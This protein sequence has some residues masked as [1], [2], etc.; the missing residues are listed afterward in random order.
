MT[1]STVLAVAAA[2]ALMLGGTSLSHAQVGSK[3]LGMEP[4]DSSEVTQV[5]YRGRART[6][7]RRWHSDGGWHSGGPGLLG[8]PFAAAAGAGMAAGSIIGGTTGAL[9][10]GP[11]AAYGYNGYGRSV[12]PYVS[13][14][15]HTSSG[16]PYYDRSGRPVQPYGHRF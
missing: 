10:G 7:N 15:V 13:G 5:R 3:A 6:M 14:G 9:F 11:Y 16:Y 2:G 4:A 12:E 8:L 1:R